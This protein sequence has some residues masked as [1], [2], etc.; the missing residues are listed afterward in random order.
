MTC[1]LRNDLSREPL[2]VRC[3]GEDKR[4]C[5]TIGNGLKV[6]KRLPDSPRVARR[7][8]KRR[9]RYEHRV[10]AER[11]GSIG[12]RKR[13]RTLSRDT[14]ASIT[15]AAAAASIAVRSARRVSSSDNMEGS[16][17]SLST[18]RPA[19]GVFE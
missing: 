1:K 18:A 14:P 2:I 15:F 7:A 8:K 5:R 3:G 9:L 17:C 11:R 13:S 16:P 4:D 6:G 12:Q 19:A 10:V